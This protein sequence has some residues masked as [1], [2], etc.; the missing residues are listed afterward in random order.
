MVSMR[1][2]KAESIDS[3]V[4]SISY[5]VNVPVCGRLFIY[6]SINMSN[7]KKPYDNFYKHY[8]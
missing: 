5:K 1:F 4:F 7:D 6:F 3:F 8:H 2:F